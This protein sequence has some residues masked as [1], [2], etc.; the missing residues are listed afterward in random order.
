M[1]HGTRKWP[2][3]TNMDNINVSNT[4]STFVIIIMTMVVN[5]AV[6]G[7]PFQTSDCQFGPILELA[8]QAV[9]PE[10]S[11]LE[12]INSNKPKSASHWC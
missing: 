3:V 8:R 5:M 11:K 7:T 12:N 4:I 1:V 2:K 9:L 10:R 6:R